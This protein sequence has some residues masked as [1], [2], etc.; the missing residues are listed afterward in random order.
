M[1]GANRESRA[2]GIG[3]VHAGT[4]SN[5][6]DAK[7]NLCTARLSAHRCDID[8]NLIT[9]HDACDRQAR[10]QPL[11]ACAPQRD[12]RTG[13]VSAFAL[14]KANCAKLRAGFSTLAHAHRH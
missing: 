4:P 9:L 6:T 7:T 8:A 12:A 5:R 2:R 13:F 11:H 3:T 14:H 1:R 10:A